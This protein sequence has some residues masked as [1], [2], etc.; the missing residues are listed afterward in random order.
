MRA[1]ACGTQW[2]LCINLVLAEG[3]GRMHLLPRPC[4][5]SQ[6]GN[7]QPATPRNELKLTRSHTAL[8][9]GGNIPLGTVQRSRRSSLD[10]GLPHHEG[11]MEMKAKAAVSVPP[12][13]LTALPCRRH[14]CSHR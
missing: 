8:L 11:S 13:S 9:Q 14:T 1:A 5:A 12:V 3:T 2:E 7:Q 10:T 4:A 6:H